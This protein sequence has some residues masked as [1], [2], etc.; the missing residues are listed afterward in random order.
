MVER[1]WYTHYSWWSVKCIT[2]AWYLIN[3]NNDDESYES[4][5]ADAAA[6]ADL[7][8]A[9]FEGL[10]GGEQGGEEGAILDS[11]DPEVLDCHHYEDKKCKKEEIYLAE[12]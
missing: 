4:Y 9:A 10:D 7:L 1:I 6:D 2:I 12:R 11:A 3:T 5:N 8:D